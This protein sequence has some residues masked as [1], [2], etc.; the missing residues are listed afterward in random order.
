MVTK[1]LL[2]CVVLNAPVVNAG[3]IVGTADVAVDHV[4][5]LLIPVTLAMLHCLN[6]LVCM[7][8]L[9]LLSVNIR[10]SQCSM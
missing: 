2:L 10:C 7:I 4:Q 5:V 8:M 6:L 1:L 9:F 3:D